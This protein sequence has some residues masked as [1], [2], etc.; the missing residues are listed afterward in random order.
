[1]GISEK[2]YI[3]YEKVFTENKSLNNWKKIVSAGI[4]TQGSDSLNQ[5]VTN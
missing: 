4:R 1:M 3:N 2:Y 5:Y